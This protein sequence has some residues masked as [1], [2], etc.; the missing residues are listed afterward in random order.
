MTL[1]PINNR[2][3]L[4]NF[5]KRQMAEIAI[6]VR[7]I[8]N[9]KNKSILLFGFFLLCTITFL[10]T[11]QKAEA[12]V[13]NDI[14]EWGRNAATKVSQNQEKI[15]QR[16]FG[17]Y[18]AAF[19]YLCYCCQGF[20]IFPFSIGFMKWLKEEDDLK[21][22]IE[23][24]AP[25]AV[26]IGL[27]N[28]GY[29]IGQIILALYKIFD[30]VI[31]TFDSYTGFYQTIKEGKAR[32]LI[33]PSLSPLFKQCEALI[34]A[35]QSACFADLSKQVQNM[36]N[37]YKQDFFNSSWLPDWLSNINEAIEQWNDPQKNV[38]DKAR[39]VF[40]TITSPAW[41]GI[42]AVILSKVTE[43]WQALYGIAF[44]FTGIAAPMAATA[45]LFTSNTFLASAYALWLTGMFTIF[46]A[47]LLLYVGYGLASDLVVSADASADTIWFGVVMA[48]VIPFCVFAIAKGGGAGVWSSLV[49]T[50][51]A[52]INTG[53][54]L[55]GAAIAGPV[56][57][58][59]AS[60]VSTTATSSAPPQNNVAVETKY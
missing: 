48:L 24:V 31:N 57:A 52:A 54:M 59:G 56:G 2:Y 14:A 28:G 6:Y 23:L 33:G 46:L 8:P 34:G 3:S 29:I 15:V 36:G 13:F 9:R 21:I 42:L 32:A 43:A 55:A 26:L 20:A 53:T 49:S 7:R 17:Q 25:A 4:T 16:Y 39:T 44:I 5:I 51:S 40:W 30:G 37:E 19:A 45:S 58:A 10:L 47:R 50:A 12:I 41:E 11:P 27:A 35:E 60:K 18:N 38:G 22:W 1:S